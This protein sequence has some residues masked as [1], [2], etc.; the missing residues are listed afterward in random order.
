MKPVLSIAAALVSLAFASSVAGQSADVLLNCSACHTV[1][2]KLNKPGAARIPSPY[3]DLN[4]QPVRYLERQLSAYRNGLRMHP[5]MTA[6]AIGLGDGAAAMARLYA[7]APAPKLHFDG[8]PDQF[9]DARKLVTEGDWSRGLP[10]CNS[11]HAQGPNER[12]LLSPRL[13]GLPANYLSGQLRAYANGTRRSD[14]LGRMRAFS[15]V[16][17]QAEISELSQYYAAWTQRDASA[18]AQQMDDGD[19]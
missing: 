18:R 6:T 4:G 10:S 15:G 19:E 11:C 8:S 3:P 12:T 16:L 7:D 9:P 14:P 1:G 5:Q 17:T 2:S 13:H